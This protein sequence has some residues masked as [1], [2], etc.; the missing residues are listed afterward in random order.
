[1]CINEARGYED[2]TCLSIFSA[3]LAAH[4]INGRGGRWLGQR[5]NTS[6]PAEVAP[7]VPPARARAAQAT[8]AGDTAPGTLLLIA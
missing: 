5:F 7:A 3:T 8:P 1:M 4:P 2:N 6:V